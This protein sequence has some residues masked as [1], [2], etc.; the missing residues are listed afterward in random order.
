VARPGALIATA[1]ATDPDASTRFS[2]SHAAADPARRARSE[3]GCFA[4]GNPSNRLRP[5]S[6]LRVRSTSGFLV[7]LALLT[8][9][10]RVADAKVWNLKEL[11]EDTGR[12]KYTGALENDFEYT[13]RHMI[14]PG[15]GGTTL[16]LSEKSADPIPDPATECLDNLIALEKC[17]AADPRVSG[18]QVEWF[19][20]LAV[21]DPSRLS[22][23]RAI[24]A[25]GHAGAR[26]QA[27]L[28]LGLAK[29][30]VPAGAEAAGEAMTQLVRAV[31][32]VL[33]SKAKATETQ[34]ADLAAACKV[35][36]DMVLDLAGARRLLRVT[37]EFA[38]SAK[39]DVPGV[40][41]LRNLSVEL[42]RRCIRQALA[43]A[44]LDPAPLVRAAAVEA[45]TR[46]AGPQVLESVLVQ[47]ERERSPE[48]LLGVLRLVRESGLPA[49]SS[50]HTQA[51]QAAIHDLELS[52]L[53]NLLGNTDGEV[54]VAA[55]LT[56]SRVSGAG[57]ASLREEDWQAWWIARQ[58]KRPL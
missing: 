2:R 4:P 3:S 36:E 23:E 37:V 50:E 5:V 40:E 25:L 35:I 49:A 14:A 52:V 58:E 28:P 10:C 8:S 13:L 12:H 17:D 24:E 33:A 26:L 39:G 41:P 46:C 47:L 20:R 16:N 45:A 48:V 21:D 29:D 44:L 30:Q 19:S 31:G 27:G 51:E 15:F 11:H 34:R 57:I 9:A 1:P 7:G 43:A 32:P 42:Q 54:R 53:Y 55:M 22:R 38:A 18:L 6:T 56:L